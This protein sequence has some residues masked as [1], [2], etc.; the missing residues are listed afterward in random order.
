MNQMVW[1][2]LVKTSMGQ[3]I[4][5]TNT[6]LY[7]EYLPKLNPRGKIMCDIPR[8]PLNEGTYYLDIMIKQGQDSPVLVEHNWY[9]C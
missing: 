2:I 1:M 9:V 6:R 8:V 3:P 5:S 7:D 4:F